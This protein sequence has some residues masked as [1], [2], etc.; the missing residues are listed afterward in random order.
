MKAHPGDHLIVEGTNLS[1]PR[2]EGVIVRVDHPDGTPPY[3]VRWLSEDNESFVVPGPTARVEP[4][5][6]SAG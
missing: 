3:L 1:D 6:A 2:R 4:A 5:L